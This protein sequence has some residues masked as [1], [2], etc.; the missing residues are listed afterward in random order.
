VSGSRSQEN[1][2]VFLEPF[3]YS[4]YMGRKKLPNNIREYFSKLGSKGGKKGGR[5]RADKMTAAERTES[6]RRAVTA[7]WKKAK[8]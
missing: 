8:G 4:V 7:R 5:A 6:A 1:N 3:T 2:V